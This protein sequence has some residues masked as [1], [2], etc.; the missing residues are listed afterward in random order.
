MRN[1]TFQIS[2]MFLFAKSICTSHLPEIKIS[3]AKKFIYF[4]PMNRIYQIFQIN[5]DK[6]KHLLIT[7][8]TYFSD[9]GL[10]AL[11]DDKKATHKLKS[12]SIKFL[13]GPTPAIPLFTKEGFWEKHNSLRAC[14]GQTD[15]QEIQEKLEALPKEYTSK[16]Y[17]PFNE[18][19]TADRIKRLEANIQSEVDIKYVYKF[20]VFIS[21]N[22]ISIWPISGDIVYP[23]L[24][25]KIPDDYPLSPAENLAIYSDV[26]V[27][28]KKYDSIQAIILES[29]SKWIADNQPSCSA[30]KHQTIF[31]VKIMQLGYLD[32]RTDRSMKELNRHARKELIDLEST[33]ISQR[34]KQK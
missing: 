24:I 9:D 6:E 19:L 22:H 20:I 31:E 11:L 17:W 23:N 15:D 5:S 32:E 1:I 30:L 26:T 13:S 29:I 4:H 7:I 21:K 2:F 16:A 18:K 33:I 28:D 3:E 25:E 27:L 14:L 12:M 10:I 8:K 34:K